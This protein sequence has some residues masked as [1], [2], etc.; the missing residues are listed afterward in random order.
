MAVP[1]LAAALI[2]KDEAQNLPE[3]LA[4]LNALRPLITEICVYDTGSTDG[5]QEIA[6]AAGATLSQGYWDGDFARARNEAIGMTNAKWVLIVDADERVSADQAAVRRSLRAALTAANGRVD[7]LRVPCTNVEENGSD[8]VLWGSDRLF[9]RS[10]AHYVGAVHEQ[11]MR[12]DGKPVVFDELSPRQ[13]L[14]RH[15]GYLDEKLLSDKLQRNLQIAEDEVAALPPGA[16]AEN[17]IR[18][19]IDRARS[20]VGAGDTEGGLADLEVVR[21]TPSPSKYRLHGLQQ[22]AGWLIDL[23]R[24]DQAAEI[25]AELAE[26]PIHQS[27]TQWLTA[28]ILFLRGRHAEALTLLR[29][30]D[31]LV[32]ATGTVDVPRPLVEARLKAAAITGEIDEA[33]ACAVRLI[34]DLGVVESYPRLLMTLWGDRELSVLAQILVD[35]D[36]GY[37]SSALPA[38][39]ELGD[40]GQE[41]AGLIRKKLAP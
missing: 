31:K 37:L 18:A 35:S 29:A 21:A 3:C 26:A 8:G 7:A 40:R 36:R 34:A 25:I 30:I 12:L 24:V 10:R 19:Y 11:V 13:I 17:L 9:R 39:E 23:E 22:Y 5:T 2:V 16:P 41:L 27:H 32:G 38:F 28:R 4:A 20:R 14:I 6:R 15:H 33:A 1:L